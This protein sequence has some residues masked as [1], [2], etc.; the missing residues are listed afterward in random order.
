MAPQ[1]EL[2]IVG[3]GLLGGSIGA[4]ARQRGLFSRVVGVCRTD[5]AAD[6]ARQQ[7]VVDEATID[8]PRGVSKA[9]M[10]VIC[11]PVSAIASVYAT[12]APA[13]PRGCVVTDA[14]STKLEL[15]SAIE[16]FRTEQ[17]NWPPFVGSHPLAGDHRCGP[18]AARPD[19][20]LDK[21]VIVTPTPATDPGALARVEQ[22]WRSLGANLGSLSPAEHDRLLA[23]SSHLP[24]LA[25]SILAGTTAEEALPWTGAGWRDTTRVAAGDP[26]L[27]ADILMSNRQ[28]ILE[29]GRALGDGL[30]GALAAIE[31]GDRDRLVE[32][33]EQGST[34][35]N[36]VGS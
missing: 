36:A 28:N 35:R 32:V 24:H 12:I 2:A 20:L 25:A 4:A 31:A 18:E 3:V 13:C 26:Q 21:T 22:F 5:R 1:G 6:R 9:S 19:L 10:V 17:P 14:G 27:W 34:R 15:I 7:R 29:A 23:A 33:L 30:R 16:A 8:A 11:T